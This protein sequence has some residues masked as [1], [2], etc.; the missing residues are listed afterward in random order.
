MGD[1][2]TPFTERLR[3]LEADGWTFSTISDTG[4]PQPIALPTVFERGRFSHVL[5]QR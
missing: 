1:E 3:G 4:E 2:W 5:M